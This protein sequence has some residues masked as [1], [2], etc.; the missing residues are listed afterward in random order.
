MSL[1]VNSAPT[2][3]H[4]LHGGVPAEAERGK[5]ENVLPQYQQLHQKVM[6]PKDAL[7]CHLPRI[8]LVNGIWSMEGTAAKSQ[9]IMQRTAQRGSPTAESELH[10]L[11]RSEFCASASSMGPQTLLH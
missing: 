2:G 9:G 7:C 3:L 4:G 11:C 10:F 5:A 8:G 1:N 6:L